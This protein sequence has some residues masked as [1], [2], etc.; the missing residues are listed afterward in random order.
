MMSTYKP[1]FPISHFSSPQLL[2]V[3]L[4][5][6]I[7]YHIIPIS[8]EEPNLDS[9][10]EENLLIFLHRA[11]SAKSIIDIR[12][13]LPIFFYLIYMVS[14]LIQIPVFDSTVIIRAF[15]NFSKAELEDILY[16]LLHRF[17]FFVLF[18]GGRLLFCSHLLDGLE[19]SNRLC[20]F[21]FAYFIDI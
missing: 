8:I 13:R 21:I 3:L 2:Q 20:W 10:V 14:M 9:F 1:R 16:R 7:G 5:V 6:S 11:I 17:D 12:A 19:H 4:G 18:L 15:R